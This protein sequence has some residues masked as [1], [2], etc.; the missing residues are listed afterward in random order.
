ML[1][2]NRIYNVDC[3]EGLKQL[4]DNSVDLTVTSP[5]YD[6]LRTYHEGDEFVWNF[7]IFK[8]IA[9]ELYRVTK[10]GCC[11]VWVVGDAVIKGGETGSSFRQA[12]E[13]QRLGFLLH[14]TMIYEKNS[15][16]FP[17]K[18][19][20]KRYSQMFEYMFVFVKGK[21]IRDDIKLIADKRNKWA[22]WTNWGKHTMYDKNGNLIPTTQNK[23]TPE[24]SLRNNIWRYTVSFNDKTNHPAVFPERLAQDH[25][26]SWS[27]EGDLVLD[28]FMGSGTTAKMAKLNKRNYIGFDKNEAYYEESLDRVKKYD[29]VVNTNVET[30]QVKVKETGEVGIAQYT[31]D[32]NDRELEGKMELWRQLLTQLE[33][34]FNEQKLS[35]LKSLT[36]TFASKSNDRKVEDILRERN[37]L[38]GETVNTESPQQTVEEPTIVQTP[39]KV[40]SI[41]NEYLSKVLKEYAK[42]SDIEQLVLNALKTLNIIPETNA[43]DETV[44][45]EAS[46]NEQSQNTENTNKRKRGTYK[47]YTYTSGTTVK[48]VA[49]EYEGQIGTIL[50][51]IQKDDDSVVY[52]ID[53]NGNLVITDRNNIKRV[54]KK[55]LRT[56]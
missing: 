43:I 52:Q 46:D 26:L 40:V 10:P 14:D 39:E 50:F 55:S 5:P 13:F 34:Y 36:F 21:K 9:K 38:T 45:E 51:V 17:A 6:N 25:I 20:A 44:P 22:G 2:I 11:V 41:D 37:L 1:E 33:K 27:V 35:I 48:F 4:D 24:F 12:L 30:T 3:I 56:V 18:I 19:S 53:I 8:E 47:K 54:N 49:G 42:K 28:P 15:S 16:T 23:P 31:A 29:G 32:E 7:E